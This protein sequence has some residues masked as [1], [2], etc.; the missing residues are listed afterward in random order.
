MNNAAREKAKAELA[1][2]LQFP[3]PVITESSTEEQ[4]RWRTFLLE[5]HT[6]YNALCAS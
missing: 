6:A 2:Y 3:L 4:Q 5:K 1:L